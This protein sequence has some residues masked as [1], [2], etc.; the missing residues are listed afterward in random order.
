[1]PEPNIPT[2]LAELQ[3]L[4]ATLPP[5][6]PYEP[7]YTTVRIRLTRALAQQ[8]V[9]LQPERLMVPGAV[10]RVADMILS[11]AWDADAIEEM[12]FSLPLRRSASS[13]ESGLHVGGTRIRAVILADVDID[14]RIAHVPP[15]Q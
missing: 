8:L 12:R 3:A 13:A 5:A 15:L 7:G 2:T 10:R 4:L 14:T 1:M 6:F 9:D 11:G